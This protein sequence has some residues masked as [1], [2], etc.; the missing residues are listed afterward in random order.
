MKIW[1]MRG[2]PGSG[3]STRARE[4]AR[5]HDAVIINRD[6]IRQQLLDSWWTGKTEDEDRVTIAEKAQVEAFL[7]QNV[8]IV[9]D[10]TNLNP[11][12]LRQWARLA[13][14]Y[15]AEFE[16]VDIKTDVDECKRRA[17]RRWT[18]E[19]GTP[20]ERYIDPRVIEAKARQFPMEKWPK[21]TA[22]PFVPEP[23]ERDATLPDAIIVDID[24]TVARNVSRSP[25]DY[26]KVLEDEL[27]P[28][29]AWLVNVLFLLR[30]HNPGEDH[31]EIIFVSGRDHTCYDDTIQWLNDN[32]IPFDRLLM[33]PADARDKQGNKLPDFFVKHQ[34]FNEH[35]RGKYNVLF[36]LDDRDQVVRTW[37]RMGLKC[38]QVA[39]GNF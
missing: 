22:E 21:I 13:T 29:I 31:P 9:I 30:Y 37:R 12:F 38:L 33:R 15:G 28:E 3:K 14:Q 4:I 10:N 18:Q 2:L 23:V 35:I 26:T 36:I 20:L 27:H 16:V 19:A 24:G 7:K 17:Y 6:L 32:N 1:A 8:N 34:L 39:E 11:K 25:F 5:Q